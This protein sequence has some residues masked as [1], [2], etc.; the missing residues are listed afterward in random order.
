M[1]GVMEYVVSGVVIALNFGLGL[2]FSLRR[3]ALASDTTTEM[4]LGSRALGSFPLAA[5]LVASA[6]SS[7]SLVGFTGH[8]YAYGFHLMWHGLNTLAMAPV[9]AFLFLPVFYGLRITSLFEV[10]EFL[11]SQN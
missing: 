11:V 4:F 3:K 8:F 7:V 10:R 2:Y 6:I 9:V 5:S 1:A